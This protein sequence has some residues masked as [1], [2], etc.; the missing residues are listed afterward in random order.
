MLSRD[1]I[2]ILFFSYSPERSARE[3]RWLRNRDKNIELHRR[4]HHRMR[5][6]ARSA[7]VDL[8]L[9]DETQQK[10][11]GFQDR[12]WKAIDSI[13]EKGYQ[14]VLA[15]GGDTPTLTASILK[16]SLD[17]LR[18]G[19][20]VLGPS[21]DGGTYLLGF[22]RNSFRLIRNHQI[23]WHAGTDFDQL[24]SILANEAVWKAPALTDWDTYSDIHHQ[25]SHQPIFWLWRKL[26]A[27]LVVSLSGLIFFICHLCQVHIF[28]LVFGMRAP[29]Q[30]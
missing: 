10:G 22:Q 29:P 6:L 3:K 17:Q 14:A 4:V 11:N 26:I 21:R 16:E 7:N 9:I 8:F 18:C 28:V 2:A 1:S 25:L 12:F 27:D 19:K 24:Q 30:R 13:F 5:N 23:E 15:M 20:N